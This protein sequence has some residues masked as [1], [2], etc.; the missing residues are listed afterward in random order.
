MRHIQEARTNLFGFGLVK[1]LTGLTVQTVSSPKDSMC[2][3]IYIYA[4]GQ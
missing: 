3:Y 4:Y 1:Q 2:V